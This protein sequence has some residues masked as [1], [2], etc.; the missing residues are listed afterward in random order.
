MIDDRIFWAVTAGLAVGTFLI[1]F[2]FLGLLGGRALPSWLALHLKYV[3]VAVFPALTVPLVL[4]PRGAS[5]GVDPV[6]L[7]A[8][9]AALV[10]GMRGRVVGSIVVGLGVF[11]LGH[12]ALGG[13]FPPGP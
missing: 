5:G 12:A 13:L 9:V 6:L 1:R 3:G 10:V 2:S 8:V 11:H 4:S 7:L